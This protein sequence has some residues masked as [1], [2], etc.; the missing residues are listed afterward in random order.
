M[1][2]V[3]NRLA[4]G[5]VAVMLMASCGGD[6]S[7]PSRQ[8]VAGTYVLTTL[9]FD[10]QGVLPEVELLGRL[11][12]NAPRLILAPA[13]EAQL[14]FQDP[15]TGLFTVVDGSYS[16]PQEGVRVDFGSSTTSYRNVLLSRRMTF[17]DSGTGVLTFDGAPPDG[18][19]RDRLVQ[20]VPEFADEQLIDPV[21]GVLV[22]VFARIEGGGT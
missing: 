4:A 21:P 8:D 2:S 1:K 3:H 16:T 7:S 5:A 14:V 13:G 18:V 17:S 12:G 15:A 22:V 10:P 20:L 6:P 19:D 9:S 11:Q